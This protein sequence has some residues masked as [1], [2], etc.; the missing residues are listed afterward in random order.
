MVDGRKKLT[1]CFTNPT[2]I[3]IFLEVKLKGK[4]TAKE[5]IRSNTEIPQA[6]L[7][8]YLKK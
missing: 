4:V 6:T 1:T 8:R 2:Q 5:R 3:K 7:Y